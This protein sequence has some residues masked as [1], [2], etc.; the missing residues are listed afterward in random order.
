M[1][2]NKIITDWLENRRVK[3]AKKKA[4]KL[5]KLYN[6]RFWVLRTESGKLEIVNRQNIK[7]TNRKLSPAERIDFKKLI[8]NAIYQTR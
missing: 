8:D 5:D 3:L 2:L 7:E 6:K 1:D 4:D